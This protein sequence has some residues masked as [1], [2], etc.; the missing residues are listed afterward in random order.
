MPQRNGRRVG[1]RGELSFWGKK[2]PVAKLKGV[3]P[4]D[5]VPTS[6]SLGNGSVAPG[7]CGQVLSERRWEGLSQ[8]NSP[9][10]GKLLASSMSCL[11]PWACVSDCWSDE[12]RALL[13]HPLCSRLLAI[14]A[15]LITLGGRGKWETVH[16]NTL[17]DLQSPLQGSDNYVFMHFICGNVRTQKG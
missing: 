6:I 12:L 13:T 10:E 8:E 14:F 2:K 9:S 7:D 1:D 3:K 17:K 4:E 16:W 15:S 5:R 11:S